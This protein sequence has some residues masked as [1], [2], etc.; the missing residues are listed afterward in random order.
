[1]LDEMAEYFDYMAKETGTLWENDTSYASCNHGFASHL[2]HIFRRDVLG[3]VEIDDKLKTVYA[4]E[5]FAAPEKVKA[6]FP[7]GS[8]EVIVTIENGK[9][10]ILVPDG[11]HLVNNF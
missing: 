4:T 2:V 7:A 8:G 1:M 9:R 3:I 11:Y 5:Q 10:G 6:Q